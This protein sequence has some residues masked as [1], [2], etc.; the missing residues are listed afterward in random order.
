[1]MESRQTVLPLP[2]APAM[3]RCGIFVRS[4]ATDSPP[5]PLPRATASFDLA[6]I[7]WNDVLSMTLLNATEPNAEFGTSIPTMDLPGIGASMR[8]LG[9]ASASARSLPSAVMRS[10]RILVLD[11]SSYRS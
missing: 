6:C 4:P 11:T 10:T 8:M 7:F 3:S 1:M 2:V 9:A 5:A